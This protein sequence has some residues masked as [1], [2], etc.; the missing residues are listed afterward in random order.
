MAAV[1]VEDNG[2]GIDPAI[3]SRIFDPFFTQKETG[4][5]LGLSITQKI[6]DQHGGRLDVKSDLGKGSTFTVLLPTA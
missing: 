2:S 3:I 6:V 1:V 4:T 5:G